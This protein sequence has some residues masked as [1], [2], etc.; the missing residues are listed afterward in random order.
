MYRDEADALSYPGQAAVRLG[1]TRTATCNRTCTT[2]WASVQAG[3]PTG[4]VQIPAELGPASW[5]GSFP[6]L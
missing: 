5:R 2:Q 1:R 6:C 4:Q 3:E